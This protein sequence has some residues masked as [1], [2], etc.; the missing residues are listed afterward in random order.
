MVKEY[1]SPDGEMVLLAR[2]RSD[3]VA[4]PPHEAST[5]PPAIRTAPTALGFVPLGKWPAPMPGALVPP[6]PK[7]MPLST[8]MLFRS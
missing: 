5:L 7:T 6:M 3:P 2:M 8:T 1:S 4:P